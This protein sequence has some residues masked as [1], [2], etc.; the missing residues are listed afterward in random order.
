LGTI[1]LK[2]M[3]KRLYFISTLILC[4][5][6]LS[7]SSCLKDARYTDF[8]KGSPVVEFNLGGLAYFGQ[9]AVTESTD[10]IVK[11]F[12]VSVASVN[13]PTTPTTITLAVDNSIV[14]TYDA[15]NP[16]VAFIPLPA[17]TFALSTT[18]VTIPAGQRA[19]IVSVTIFKGL[20]DPALSYLLPIKIAGTSGGYI[21][22]GNMGIHYYHI[23]GNDFA[24]TYREKFQ[25][26]NA[27]D[28]TSIALNGASFPFSA[29]VTT[30]FVPISPTEFTVFSGYVTGAEF[31]YDVTFTKTGSGAS[32]V[33][34]NFHVQFI[35]SDVAA[36]APAITVAT[37]PVFFDPVTQK[38]ATAN[39]AGPYT[40]AQAE[41]IFHFQW[42]PM[43]AARRYIL[44]TYLK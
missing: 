36:Q 9:D 1:N 20:L 10:T 41:T 11:Q 21:I 24:G 32:A 31:R 17:N 39:L 25:R 18:S 3:K 22:S 19:A 40:F 33:Y 15:A 2:D 26:Y 13:L 44:D 43:T 4:A 8:S 34:T 14:T 12:A 35:A 37:T 7:L 42:G 28:S 30:T 6:L 16:A 38:P 27:A 29:G 5:A 23:I